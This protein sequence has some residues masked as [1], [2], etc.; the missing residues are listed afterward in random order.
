M[1]Q[2]AAASTT[3][4]SRGSSRF[5]RQS[6]PEAADRSHPARRV[7]RANENPARTERG[8]LC[9][10]GGLC[11]PRPK[12]SQTRFYRL[13]RFLNLGGGSPDRHGAPS[14]SRMD[15]WSALSASGGPHAAISDAHHS[16]RAAPDGMDGWATMAQ[17]LRYTALGGESVSRGGVLGTYWLPVLTWSCATACHAAPASP[18]E[19]GSPPCM[20]N[21]IAQ[22]RCVVKGGR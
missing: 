1:L 3:R 13:I 21:S 20:T 12:D 19:T 15:L 16:A 8:L 10:G 9:G 17:H 14:P 11:N 4:R 7:Y 22:N 5:M 6:L 2:P 18:V